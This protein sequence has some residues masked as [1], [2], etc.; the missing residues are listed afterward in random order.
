MRALVPSVLLLLA[1]ASLPASP[2]TASACS[3]GPAN[4]CI[5]NALEWFATPE[6]YTTAG[7]TM[8]PGE[9]TCHATQQSVWVRLDVQGAGTWDQFDVHV[10]APYYV[11]LAA[12]ERPDA[13]TWTLRGCSFTTYDDDLHRDD[14]PGPI[15]LRCAPGATYWIQVGSQHAHG[16]GAFALWESQFLHFNRTMS[17]PCPFKH[18]LPGRPSVWVKPG[19]TMLDVE[20]HEG[21]GGGRGVKNLQLHV[22]GADSCAGPFT[23]L[24]SRPGIAPRW[25]GPGAFG[26]WE[27]TGLGHGVTRCYRV[28]G[29]NYLG[30]GALSAPL[31]ATTWLLPGAPRITS[32]LPHGDGEVRIRWQPPASTGGGPITGYVL[33]RTD[34]DGTT[35]RAATLPGTT[36]THVDVGLARGATYTYALRAVTPAGE[37]A[38]ASIDATTWRVVDAPR[39]VEVRIGL[40]PSAEIT[41][42]SPADT[43]P[44][45]TYRVYRIGAGNAATLVGEVDH[46]TTRFTDA[47]LRFATSGTYEVRAWNP[48]GESAPSARACDAWP[49]QTFVTGC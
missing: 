3:G 35:R 2:A 30:E 42:S 34:P 32:A 33:D 44:F 9:P 6:S 19:G 37:G 5:A 10:E 1:A 31:S 16:G 28:S 20:W 23:R 49:A 15:R 18:T 26:S 4:D 21:H 14:P 17:E 13:Q 25:S 11:T 7:A 27:E 8:E 40:L 38:A 22:Y 47:T 29:E 41:W 39:D 24:A 46:R 48:A 36:G 43:A 45:Q 12:Y